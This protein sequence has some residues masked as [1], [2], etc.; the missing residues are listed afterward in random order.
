M[1]GINPVEHKKGKTPSSPSRKISGQIYDQSR[2]PSYPPP[3]KP[4]DPQ[5]HPANN[6]SHP[7]GNRGLGYATVPL[8]VPMGYP[9]STGDYQDEINY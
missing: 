9:S 4:I 1:P 8:N 7:H 2:S 6:V 3:S 5:D